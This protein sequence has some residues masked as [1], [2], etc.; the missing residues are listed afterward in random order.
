MQGKATAWNE[1]TLTPSLAPIKR[2]IHI[3]LQQNS[4]ASKL[5]LKIL[6]GKN[7][8][9]IA[10]EKKAHRVGKKSIAKKKKDREV[11]VQFFFS[12]PFIFF[13]CHSNTGSKGFPKTLGKTRNE[14][15]RRNV[16]RRRKQQF[17]VAVEA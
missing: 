15:A 11:G 16:R 13:K 9:T 14:R 1:C 5:Q 4:N 8:K 17:R 10:F 6:V 3:H 2:D 7:R 12:F